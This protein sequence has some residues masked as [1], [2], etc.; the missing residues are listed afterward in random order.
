MNVI[1]D[2]KARVAASIEKAQADLERASRISIVYRSRIQRRSVTSLTP[3][4]TT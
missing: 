4:T 2:P 1:G 3:S